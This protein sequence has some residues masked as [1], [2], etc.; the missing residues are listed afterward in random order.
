MQNLDDDPVYNKVMDTVEKAKCS[1]DRAF[2]ETLCYG[3]VQQKFCQIS[4]DDDSSDEVKVKN[5]DTRMEHN[6]YF[7][8][9]TL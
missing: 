6:S 8:D 2:R 9:L 7:K 3:I 5:E 4:M 1:K